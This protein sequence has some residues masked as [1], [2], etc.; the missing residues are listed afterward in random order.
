MSP[1]LGTYVSR[2]AI[3]VEL[4]CKL[5][6]L[7][8]CRKGAEALY[9]DL[10]KA[11]LLVDPSRRSRVDT[12]GAVVGRTTEARHYTLRGMPWY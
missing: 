7:R 2:S 12:I 10:K 5:L 4:A 3:H 9:D 8:T 6:D 1:W 11:C